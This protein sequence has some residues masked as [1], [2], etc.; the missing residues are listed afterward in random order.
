[1]LDKFRKRYPEGSL[2]SELITIDHGKYVVKVLLQ[3]NSVTLSTGLAAD[4]KIET[5]EDRAIERALNISPRYNRRISTDIEV[6]RNQHEE[7]SMLSRITSLRL[8]LSATYPKRVS[9]RKT[10]KN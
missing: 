10:T 6:M 3:N 7:N 9:V 5:A 2:V 4:E 1:M 8:Y